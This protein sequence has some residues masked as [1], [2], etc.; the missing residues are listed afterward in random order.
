[1]G[2]E[3]NLHVT[4]L[5]R[6]LSRLWLCMRFTVYL[7]RLCQSSVP[8]KACT[9]H[10]ACRRYMCTNFCAML[11]IA[12]SHTTCYCMSL[13]TPTR[14][15]LFAVL[16]RGLRKCACTLQGAYM[17]FLKRP[18]MAVFTPFTGTQ[19]NFMSSACRTHV[20]NYRH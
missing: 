20:E 7:C 18:Y 12:A 17:S 16:Q 10:L 15:A 8:C 11:P 2:M 3:V 5:T 6:N 14:T 4:Y 13:L 1:M 9:S 19:G